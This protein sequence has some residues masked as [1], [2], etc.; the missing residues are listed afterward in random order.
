ML[1]SGEIIE[2]KN[3]SAKAADQ[4]EPDAAEILSHIDKDVAAMWHTHTNG[5]A[6]LSPE[7]WQ[8]F[9]DWPQIEHA[10]VAS[11]GVRYYGVRGRGVINLPGATS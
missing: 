4:F 11:E 9:L 2:L 7:D 5:S 6:N 8:T 1:V 10:I 3:M